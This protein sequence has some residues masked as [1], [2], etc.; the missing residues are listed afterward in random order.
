MEHFNTI[1]LARHFG[2][3]RTFSL[4]WQEFAALYAELKGTIY[5]LLNLGNNSWVRFCGAVSSRCGQ[6]LFPSTS[7]LP[8]LCAAPRSQTP[9]RF[10][11]STTTSSE[12]VQQSRAVNTEISS[13][14][15]PQLGRNARNSI[16]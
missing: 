4:D 6:E 11:A 9:L 14:P 2:S 3:L 16:V 8:R 1:V 5:A 7:A 10:R 13:T 12:A 15:A